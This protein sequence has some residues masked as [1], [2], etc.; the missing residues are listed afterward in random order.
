[1]KKDV[2]EASVE[3]VVMPWINGEKPP[4]EEWVEVQSGNGATT[5][6]MAFYGRDGWRPHWRTV[7]GSSCHPSRFNTWRRN[8]NI[9]PTTG[10]IDCSKCSGEYCEKHF[11]KPCEC[12]VVE[13]HRPSA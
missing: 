3:S 9:C 1:M 10:E 4:N 11:D 5:V 7:D 2:D 6:A 8:G 12:E 13:R